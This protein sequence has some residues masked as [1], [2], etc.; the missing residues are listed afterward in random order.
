M[1]RKK[2]Q[3]EVCNLFSKDNLPRASVAKSIEAVASLQS[4]TESQY[5]SSEKTEEKDI[6]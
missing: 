6:L 3:Y 1:S 4:E 5:T 2:S